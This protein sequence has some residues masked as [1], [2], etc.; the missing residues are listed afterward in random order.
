MKK[1]KKE[2]QNIRTSN[3]TTNNVT[4]NNSAVR[5]RKRSHGDNAGGG[6][7]TSGLSLLIGSVMD[8]I[9]EKMSLM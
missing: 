1:Q 6:K 4:T 2:L 9:P 5:N 7:S 3:A 8:N